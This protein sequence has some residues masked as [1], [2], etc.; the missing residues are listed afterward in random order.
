MSALS[1][2]HGEGASTPPARRLDETHQSSIREALEDLIHVARSRGRDMKLVSALLRS[3]AEFMQEHGADATITAS[4]GSD[5]DPPGSHEDARNPAAESPLRASISPALR[6]RLHAVI[7]SLS[8]DETARLLGIGT[9]QVRRRALAG[10]LYFFQVGR[11]RR[12]PCWQFVGDNRVLHGLQDVTP[13]L[14]R[15]WPPETVDAFMTTQHPHLLLRGVPVSPVE[16]LARG[17]DP[18]NVTHL[19]ASAPRERG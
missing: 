15:A 6:S 16:W 3:M 14:P 4:T 12:Y 1:L 8:D 18:R 9:R 19:L 10:G 7:D 13:L 11:R 5:V 2:P 17:G